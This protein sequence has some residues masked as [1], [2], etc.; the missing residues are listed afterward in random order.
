[1][2]TII[3][4]EILKVL[5]TLKKNRRFHNTTSDHGGPLVR[6]L[7]TLHSILFPQRVSLS[8]LHLLQLFSP[9]LSIICSHETDG[10]VTLAALCS[11]SKFLQQDFL[12]KLL[13]SGEGQKQKKNL[14]QNENENENEKEN[15]KQEQK[16]TLTLINNKKN[17]NYSNPLE[18]IVLAITEYKFVPTDIQSDKLI[19]LQVVRTLS[20]CL[21]FGSKVKGV[22][23]NSK[24]IL[25]LFKTISRIREDKHMPKVLNHQVSILISKIAN[26]IFFQD[27]W[28]EDVNIRN[29][30]R[31]EIFQSINC[32]NLEISKK[33]KSK[34]NNENDNNNFEKLFN[35]K[36]QRLFKILFIQ[37]NQ[38]LL[39]YILG[40]RCVVILF[41]QF[42]ES[43]KLELGEIFSELIEIVKIK[44]IKQLDNLEFR[45]LIL[46]NLFEIILTG[47]TITHL[48]LNYDSDL[49]L[50]FDNRFVLKNQQLYLNRNNN[51][52]SNSRS[53]S[54]GRNHND[55]HNH[56][57]TLKVENHNNRNHN[58][59]HNNNN[60]QNINKDEHNNNK[61]GKRNN[62][63]INNEE[64]K[65][66]NVFQSNDLIKITPLFL[67]EYSKS[68]INFT[69][70][71]QQFNQNSPKT[72]IEL[73][74]ETGIISKGSDNFLGIAIFLRAAPNLSKK[75]L[76][77]ELGHMKNIKLLNA[78]VSTFDFTG[79]KFEVCIRMLLSSFR[80]PP[81]AQQIE[82]VLEAFSKKIYVES[83]I[84]KYVKNETVTCVLA[85]S[86]VMLNT[87]MYNPNVINKMTLNEF[88]QN[89]RGLN[90]G[91]N[92]PRGLLIQ[93]YN[94]IKKAEIRMAQDGPA[95][96]Q[97][98]QPNV[99]FNHSFWIHLVYNRKFD[100]RI[101]KNCLGNLTN[102]TLRLP[103]TL[104]FIKIN[105]K[106]Q[107]I[108]QCDREIFSLIYPPLLNYSKK[109]FLNTDDQ[110]IEKKCLNAFYFCAKLAAQFHLIN[111]FEK[112]LLLLNRIAFQE[113]E[114]Y[115]MPKI[116]N[117]KLQQ[118]ILF[119]FLTD[120]KAQMTTFSFFK[121]VYR[122]RQ[123]LSLSSWN[124]VLQRILYFFKLGILP[125]KLIKFY[126][127]SQ[128]ESV[129][130]IKFNEIN[131]NA[132]YNRNFNNIFNEKYNL[133]TNDY[134]NK[135]QINFLNYISILS[136]TETE[137]ETETEN[138]AYTY[139]DTNT[140]TNMSVSIDTEK[141][142]VK[143]EVSRG[144]MVLKK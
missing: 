113:N 123:I 41:K 24:T 97:I 74:T 82:R 85:Y 115:S 98:Y 50:L 114:F 96:L 20:D 72:A 30:V 124:F 10:P 127:F 84:S 112:I 65:L 117:K 105:R 143:K 132:K 62:N 141:G 89:H 23:L 76:G 79:L 119:N 7:K 116:L 38:D 15:E 120:R 35:E 47:N 137:T 55:S 129:R 133:C 110:L 9:F 18:T 86:M 131:N 66:K 39:L 128:I 90:E 94:S 107:S 49:T 95:N 136:E 34:N 19:F 104:P 126:D 103:C 16:Q 46:Q 75:V 61:N 25:T 2:E 3:S 99:G 125:D 42:W 60:N 27:W 31:I 11:I 100:Q 13:P 45:E 130:T 91:E 68:R 139:T 121:L 28:N 63:S 122:F 14:S 51:G 108:L 78:F 26:N 80:L 102:S 59:N 140:D 32:K 22:S 142:Y 8:S 48:F 6:S 144:G 54:N 12:V 83:T 93:I 70:A 135:D 21:E 134:S 101:A 88:I 92:I 4:T 37:N 53:G 36:I 111:P 87:D 1:M 40:L 67:S 138:E 118:Q 64:K 29:L 43:L 106:E 81:E 57:T 73:L 33:S 77:E 69:K 58:H 56:G 17:L 109:L 71:I 52:G 5:S 44:D